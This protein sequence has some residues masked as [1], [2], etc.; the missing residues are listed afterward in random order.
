MSST[1]APMTADE[2]LTGF[3]VGSFAIGWASWLRLMKPHAETVALLPIALRRLLELACM[4]LSLSLTMVTWH[5]V[6]SFW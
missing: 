3:L 1:T 4:G 5:V 6:V 2:L